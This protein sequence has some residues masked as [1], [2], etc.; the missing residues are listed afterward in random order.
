LS[1][2]SN[3]KLRDIAEE[4]VTTGVLPGSNHPM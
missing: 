1:M 3:R 2:Q 4:L